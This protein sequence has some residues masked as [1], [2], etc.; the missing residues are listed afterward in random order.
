M[1]QGI[2][3]DVL[4]QKRRAVLDLLLTE[5]GRGGSDLYYAS[6]SQVAAH[7]LQHAKSGSALSHDE[8]GLLDGLSRRDI[9]LLLSSKTHRQAS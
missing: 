6:T 4:E 5:V 3:A 9:E 8:L 1:K 2:T 7:L